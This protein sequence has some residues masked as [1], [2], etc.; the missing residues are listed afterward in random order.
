LTIA[1]KTISIGGSA[2]MIAYVGHDGL[3]EFS[4]DK[5]PQKKNDKKRETIILS[6][7]SKKYFRYGIE[8]S[9]AS[10]LLWSTGLMSPEAYTLEAALAGWLK[11][12]T[13]EQIRTRASAAY[14]K[15]QKCGIKA[16]TRLLVTGW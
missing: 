3:M 7:I 13:P 5:F 16:A 4:L 1:D 6:C 12:E 15:Y 11:N 8:Q 14:H 2:Q 9:G 10:P